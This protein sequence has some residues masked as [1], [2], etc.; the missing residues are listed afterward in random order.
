M[1]DNGNLEAAWTYHDAT[2]HSYTSI[3]TNPHFMDWSISLCHSRFIPRLEP[4]RLLGELRKPASP[5]FPPSRKAS[6]S[7]PKHRRTWRRW[8][9]CSTSPLAS[10]ERGAIPAANS[11]FARRRALVRSTKSSSISFAVIWQT[12][13]QASIISPPP[14]S[15]CASLR[16]GD[17]RGVLVEATGG[18]PTVAHAPLSIICTCTYWRNAWK[19]QDRTYRH[20]GW[21]NG[22]LL[23]NLLA[24]ATALGL[25]AQ[26]GLRF[27]GRK[28]Q[29]PA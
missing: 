27:R 25:P 21:D 22:T 2:K 15:A 9:N 29:P 14:S 12:Y 26:G 11:T 16:A 24:V 18:E 3:R 7:G 13:R 10:P 23:A 19:Y 20:F 5:L 28:R 8:P 4:M 6:L 17:Y 1:T